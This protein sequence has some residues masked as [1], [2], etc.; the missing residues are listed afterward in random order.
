MLQ[1]APSS[2]DQIRIVEWGISFDG[3]TAAL[4]GRVECFGCTGAATV[5]T[6]NAADIVKYGDPLG[7]GT[8]ITLGTTA[9][10]FT[11]SGEGTVANWRGFDTQFIAPTN[12]Y[13][14]QFPMGREPM[15]AVSTFV[16]IRVT[17]GTAVNAYCYLVWAE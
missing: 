10:G 2:T 16:R 1:I 11:A 3:S 7:P 9:S 6:L 13:V 12:Q 17:F 5:T 4:P 14:K 8:S 15:S